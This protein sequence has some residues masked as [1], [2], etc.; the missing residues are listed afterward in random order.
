MKG[1]I[2]FFGS[3]KHFLTKIVAYRPMTFSTARHYQVQIPAHSGVSGY[4]KIGG[5]HELNKD[6]KEYGIFALLLLKP[7]VKK[8]GQGT[9]LSLLNTSLSAHIA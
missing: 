4:F 7:E 3:N 9:I 2:S 8:E 5:G 6:H 1:K